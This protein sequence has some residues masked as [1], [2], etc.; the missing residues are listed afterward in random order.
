MAQINPPI[1]AYA[2]PETRPEKLRYVKCSLWFMVGAVLGIIAA[3]EIENLSPFATEMMTFFLIVFACI[4]IAFIYT[5]VVMIMIGVFSIHRHAIK[6]PC[7][8]R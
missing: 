4:V 6:P 8:L 7:M 3:A 2:D 5:P 1:L